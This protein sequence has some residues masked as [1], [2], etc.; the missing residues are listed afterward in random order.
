MWIICWSTGTTCSLRVFCCSNS[1]KF[2]FGDCLILLRGNWESKPAKQKPLAAYLPLGHLGHGRPLWTAK[3]SSVWQK[4]QPKCA[5]FRQKSQKFSAEGA[6]PP[7]QSLPPMGKE[8]PLTRPLT[9]A[10]QPS[11]P[12]KFFPNF[13]PYARF[14]CCYWRIW[15]IESS[16]SFVSRPRHI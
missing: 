2:N 11:T 9:S 12:S 3:K 13:Y 10:P 16:A 15:E 1:R 6:Q 8:I 14:R 4:M 7:P 5:I